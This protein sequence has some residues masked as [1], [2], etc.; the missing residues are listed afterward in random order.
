ML[1]EEFKNLHLIINSVTGVPCI[2]SDAVTESCITGTY[3]VIPRKEWYDALIK[4]FKCFEN[5]E[6]MSQIDDDWSFVFGGRAKSK[7]QLIKMLE[8]CIETVKNW[9]V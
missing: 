5:G 1:L 4:Y 3:K 6:K 9:T 2:I 8:D 7:R